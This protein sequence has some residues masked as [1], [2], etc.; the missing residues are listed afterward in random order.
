MLNYLLLPV[1][2]LLGV[3]TSFEDLKFGKIRNKWTFSAIIYALFVYYV[4]FFNGFLNNTFVSVELIT[5]IVNIVIS[6]LVGY[7]LWHFNFWSAGDGKLFIAFAFLVPLSFYSVGGFE[8]FPAFTLLFN[9]FIPL[10]V[11]LFIKSLTKTNLKKSLPLIKKEFSFLSVISILVSVIGVYWF[12]SFVFF[13][14]SHEL[15]RYALVLIIIFIL[16]NYLEKSYFYIALIFVVIRAIFSN[17]FSLSFLIQTLILFVLFQVTRIML[18]TITNND[19][20]TKIKV[21]KLKTGMIL[22]TN[23]IWKEDKCSLGNI[24]KKLV[25]P[26]AEGLNDEE[27][28]KIQS[29]KRDFDQVEIVG[30]THFAFYLFVGVLLT[31][32]FGGNFVIRIISF[33]LGSV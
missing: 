26:N 12:V 16:K 20:I 17:I 9:T 3:L 5:I 14:I 8:F 1:I 15:L 7:F 23:V 22:A 25:S 10:G 18:I 29:A 11:V 4:F 6:I 19:F 32:I 31:L 27:V 2:F 21:S 13:F 28:N 30:T 24:G 33:F